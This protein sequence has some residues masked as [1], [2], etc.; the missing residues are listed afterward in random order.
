MKTL[1]AVVLAIAISVALI[2]NAEA[3]NE[4][5]RGFRTELGAISA[6]AAVG[7]GIGLVGGIVTSGPYYAPPCEPIYVEPRIYVRPVPR[8]REAGSRP[9]T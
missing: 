6:R 7:L 1:I 3:G 8:W 4:F 2:S 9:V 5:E